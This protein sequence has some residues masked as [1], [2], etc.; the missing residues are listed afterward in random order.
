[1]RQ[2]AT[3]DFAAFEPPPP[4]RSLKPQPQPE[5]SSR[6]MSGERHGKREDACGRAGAGAASG[7]CASRVTRPVAIRAAASAQGRRWREHGASRAGWALLPPVEEP[8]EG[9]GGGWRWRRRRWRRERGWRRR[10]RRQWGWCRAWRRRGG[11]GGLGAA[12][13]RGGGAADGREGRA[14]PT[15]ANHFF[16]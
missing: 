6:D 9:G 5:K 16:V 1:M 14:D 7:C 4:F 10:R 13:R 11:G 8:G 2:K 12:A 3:L 15:P